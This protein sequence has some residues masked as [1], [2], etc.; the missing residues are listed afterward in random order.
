MMNFCNIS[1]EFW[2]RSQKYFSHEG[3]KARRS[4]KKREYESA[5]IMEYKNLSEILQIFF[6]FKII[7]VNLRNLLT[8]SGSSMGGEL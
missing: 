8:I 5:K 1:A 6:F 4:Y 7:R 2:Y 3:T